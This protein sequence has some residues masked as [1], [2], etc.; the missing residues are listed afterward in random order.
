MPNKTEAPDI[1]LWSNHADAAK[2]ELEV[3]VYVFTKNYIVYQLPHTS[4]LKPYIKRMF[5]YE[6]INQV[7]MGAAT[8]MTVRNINVDD[9]QTEN[10]IDTVELGEVQHAQSV[11]EQ[12][13]YGDDIELFNH[14][15]HGL[16]RLAG[17][18]VEYKWP[19]R[20][21]KEKTF[22]VIKQLSQSSIVEGN[23]AWQLEDN[24]LDLSSVD[25]SIKV[26]S[27]NQVLVI[28]KQIYVFNINKFSKLFKYD[29]KKQIVLDDKIEQI[30]KRFKLSFPEGLKLKDFV[31]TSAQ[32]A[33]KLMRSEPKNVTQE[34]IIDQADKFDLAMMTDDQGA[35]IIMDTRDALM[36]A[37]LLNDD[38]VESDMTD[39]HYLA[40]KKKEVFDT[41]D[42]QMNLG[43]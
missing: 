27:D 1:F 15:D 10:V 6:N 5:L 38:Y 24:K 9:G 8:G 13:A 18:L 34:Q 33:E 7:S 35:I 11:I 14:Q 26:P 25:A 28:D 43:A 3:S 41:E 4:L 42:K 20:F 37:N 31:T 29:A 30:N 12:I 16:K 32:L 39:K 21:E 2:D 23:S 36:F 19:K 40:T 22:Y 17:I